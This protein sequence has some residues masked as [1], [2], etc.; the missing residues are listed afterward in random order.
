MPT[1][2]F[3]KTMFAMLLTTLVIAGGAVFLAPQYMPQMAATYS[4][5][6]S[7]VFDA[8][9]TKYASASILGRLIAEAPRNNAYLIR[10]LTGKKPERRQLAAIIF[11]FTD[12]PLGDSVHDLIGALKDSDEKVKIY[13]AVGLALRRD[14]IA[15]PAIEQ[16]I[17]EAKSENERDQLQSCL[18]GLRTGEF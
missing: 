4:P 11:G 5:F 2:T 17:I 6:Y 12:Y 15:E 18:D 13:V 3:A 14:K 7:H 8:Y 1:S 16:A 9:L 10:M